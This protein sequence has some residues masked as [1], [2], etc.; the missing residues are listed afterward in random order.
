[1]IVNDFCFV[2]FAVACDI[3]QVKFFKFK[4]N[5]CLVLPAFQLLKTS[6]NVGSP[7]QVWRPFI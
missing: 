4:H 6:T 1:M 5:S 3:G 2:L 7:S